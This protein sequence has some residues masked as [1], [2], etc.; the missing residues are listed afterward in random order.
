MGHGKRDPI[1]PMPQRPSRPCGHPLCPG[2]AVK[3][4]RCGA[5]QQPGVYEQHR[6]TS[7]QRGYGSAWSRFARG[8][9]QRHPLCAACERQGRVTACEQVDHQ[10]PLSVWTGGKYDES[11]LQA[12]CSTCHARKTVHERESVKRAEG[13]GVPL[14]PWPYV[15]RSL[16]AKV[17]ELR[18]E[19]GSV[20]SSG[21]GVSAGARR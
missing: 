21:R 17:P 14:A 8:Y 18:D 5:H 16:A 2:V 6:G 15:R 13:G 20:L 4:G 1:S 11:N 19:W 10:I 3:H 12:L 9:R 7:T